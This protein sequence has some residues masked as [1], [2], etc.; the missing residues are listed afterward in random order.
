[1]K[2]ESLHFTN[3]ISRTLWNGDWH[4]RTRFERFQWFKCFVDFE[5]EIWRKENL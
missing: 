3:D 5:R 1:M 4:T 2:R